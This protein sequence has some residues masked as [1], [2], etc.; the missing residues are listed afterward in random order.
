MR[1]V[2]YTWHMIVLALVVLAVSA[3]ANIGSPEGGPR[4]YTP[5]VML[6]SNP[7]PGAVNFKGKKIEINFD[8]IVN[9][10]DQTTRVVVSPAPKEQPAIRAQGKK[11]VV[12]F[13]NELEP[14]TTYVIDFT[15]AIEDNNEGNV[16][17]GFSFAFSTGDHVDSLQV[18]G[19]VLRA[20]DLEPMKN[21]LVGLHS[22]LNDSA[23]TSL[24]FDRVSRT[25]SRGE[26]TLRN[27]SPGEYHIFALRDIDGDYK[28]VR[29]EDVAFLDQVIVPSTREFNSQ[30]TVFTF[31]QRIDTIIS[32]THTEFLPN[33][34][35]LS[36]FNEDYRSLYFK[37]GERTAA[38]KLQVLF[39]AALPEMPITRVLEP[40]PL[41]PDDWAK[42]ETREA[43]DSLVYWLTD[44]ALIKA[45]TVK[46]E[47]TYWNTAVNDSLELKT[48][49]VTFALK[50]S[51][52][53]K[54]EREKAAKEREKQEKELAKLE[55][56][57]DKLRREG[58]DTTDVAYERDGLRDM[59][60]VKPKL[61]NIET[62]KGQVEITDSLWIKAEAPIGRISMAGIHLEKMRS[63][64]TWSI[65]EVPTLVPANAWNLY[66]Y[67]APMELDQNTDY[68]LTI[69]SLAI[70][71]IYG[72]ACDTIRSTFKVKGEEEYANLHVR[73]MGFEG[74]AFACLLDRNGRVIRK[75]DVLG[76]YADFYDVLPD[77]YY[78][79][80]VLDANGNERWDTGNYSQHLQPEDVFYYHNSIK[81]KKYSDITL[82]W[83]IY[84]V[85]VDKQKPEAIRKYHPEERNSKL[86]KKENEKK[87]NEE[88][89][90]DEF[91]SNGFI[92][93]SSYSGNKYDD[94]KRGVV[95]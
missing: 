53:E 60:K 42:I 11:I 93:N 87:G 38:N 29:T 78:I 26:F 31:D 46:L 20:N 30:D 13:Q 91:N 84:E 77:T 95:K 85:P 73:C 69:D 66:R 55:E 5:P 37:K 68:R 51:A 71:S 25:N 1:R 9:L 67:V 12:E 92:N 27:V 2:K 15:D 58:K 49:T 88:D 32:A 40:T 24:P 64:S 36:L 39:S 47:M 59:L 82:T 70:E 89:E 45:D 74:K 44:S 50:H 18:S 72:I 54:R 61:L 6:R 76:S 48:D 17:D 16:L 57:L 35:L 43:Q 90:E 83:N 8:E 3:C 79:M 10:K 41:L 62:S 86:K 19:M 23:F 34:L 56:K 22:N 7:M 63:D 65:V 94:V 81:L 28:M 52:S 80:M 21:V 4:D 75:V 33:D 14:N